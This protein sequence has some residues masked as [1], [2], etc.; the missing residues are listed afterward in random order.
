MKR[1]SQDERKSFSNSVLV[2]LRRIA[3][4]ASQESSSFSPVSRIEREVALALD[5]L[6]STRETHG[7]IDR[8]LLRS[9]ASINTEI[10]GVE[11]R[12][13]RYSVYRFP[14]LEKFLRQRQGVH[15]ERRRHTL[16]KHKDFQAL[17]EN[18]WGL[19]ERHRMLD[20]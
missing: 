11:A 14:E 4:K 1:E 18:L 2:K 16:S 13:P 3:E 19:W 8:D 6:D 20:T 7:F 10:M 9:E 5:A 17:Y 12:N 15:A